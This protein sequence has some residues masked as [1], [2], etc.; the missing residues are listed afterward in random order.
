MQKSDYQFLFG[1]VPSRRFGRS[2]GIDLTPH[3]TCSLDCIFCQ[4]GRTA[5]KTLERKIYVPTAEV[6]AEID[7]WLTAD[8]DADYLTLSGSGEPTL[9]AEFG[10]VLNH[11]R[12]TALPSVLLTNGTLFTRADV[13]AAAAAAD[14]VKISLSAWDQRT[15]EWVNRPHPDLV[16]DTVLDGLRRF[17]AGFKGQLWLEVFLLQGFNAMAKDVEKIARL[18]E[19]LQPDRVHLNTIARPPAETFAAAVPLAELEKL[20][21]HFDPPAQIAVDAIARRPT[22]YT[23]DAATILAMLKRRPCTNEQIQAAFGLHINEVSKYL[24]LLMHRNLIVTDRKNDNI[25]YRST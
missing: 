14:V 8:G 10:R 1:P 7:H 21:M 3:K 4:L 16:F 20:S 11:L 15:F 5:E 13:R 19:A 2:L 9:H 25:Y 12:H 23:A 6:I 18:S 17:R 24:G 22:S